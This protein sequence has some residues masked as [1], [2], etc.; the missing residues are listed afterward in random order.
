MRRRRNQAALALPLALVM[1]VGCGS[2]EEDRIPLVPVSGTVTQNGKPLAGAT[3]TFM[4]D[5]GNPYNTPGFDSTG[6]EGNYKLKFKQRSGISAGKYTVSVEPA[7]MDAAV[8]V[9]EGFEDDPLMGQMAL[10][11]DGT[12]Q[13]KEKE[14]AGA[15]SEFEA[16]VDDEGG[17]FDFDVKGALK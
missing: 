1:L 3:I 6:P 2:S 10:G 5:P 4:P 12:A 9:P 17:T 14:T 13:K 11:V 7:S 16:E 15:K 8:A